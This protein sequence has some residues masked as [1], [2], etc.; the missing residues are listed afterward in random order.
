MLCIPLFPKL[1]T[2]ASLQTFPK[3]GLDTYDRK[4][5]DYQKGEKLNLLGGKTGKKP[6]MEA[7]LVRTCF[8]RQPQL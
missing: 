3:Q 5:E 8:L 1:R 2:L 4:D 7:R 6:S